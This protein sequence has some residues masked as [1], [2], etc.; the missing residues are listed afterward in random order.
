MHWWLKIEAF[1][2]EHPKLDHHRPFQMGSL[3]MQGKSKLTPLL[4]P[5]QGLINSE[6]GAPQEMAGLATHLHYHEPSNYVLVSFLQGGLFH[7]LCR[8][9]LKGRD[10][11]NALYR[12]YSPFWLAN[13]S[14]MEKEIFPFLFCFFLSLKSNVKTIAVIRCSNTFIVL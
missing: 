7:R 1:R 12:A 9:G 4:F 8:P 14:R 2:P 11:F 5:L 3:P 13:V 10:S 6:T